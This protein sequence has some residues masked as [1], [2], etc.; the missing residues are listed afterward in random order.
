MLHITYKVTKL[1]IICQYVIL[2][3]ITYYNQGL[4]YVIS[5]VIRTSLYL[6][7]I[8]YLYRNSIL[9]KIYLSTDFSVPAV[10]VRFL[11]LTTR[12]DLELG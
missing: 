11:R 5:H 1:V 8:G 12:R 7:M 10:K 6:V 2:Q 9:D 4:A 3:I